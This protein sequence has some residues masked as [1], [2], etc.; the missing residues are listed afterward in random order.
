MSSVA[1]LCAVASL[2]ISTACTIKSAID[3]ARGH[4]RR[5]D[6][7]PYSDEDGCSTKEKHLAFSRAPKFVIFASSVAGLLLT[8]S[9]ATIATDSFGS[10]LEV[11]RNQAFP[12]TSWVCLIEFS[13]AH[14]HM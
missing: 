8:I 11:A 2:C 3:T 13:D 9:L 14:Q 10:A 6:V 7:V 4:G 5:R 1:D 12:A